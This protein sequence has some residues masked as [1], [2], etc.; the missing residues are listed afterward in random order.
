VAVMILAAGLGTRFRP[1]SAW[2]AKPLAPVGDRPMLSHV[3]ERVRDFGGPIVV[4]A[5]HHREQVR[6]FLEG[7]APNVFISEEKELLGTAGGI[8]RARRYFGGQD[9]LVWNGDILAQLDVQALRGAHESGVGRAGATLVVRPRSRGDGN[10]GVDAAGHVVRLR[11]ETVRPGETRGGEFLGIHVLGEALG[12]R[13]PPSGGLIEDVF[14]P[15]MKEGTHLGVWETT[16]AFHDIGTLETYLAANLAWLE[17]NGLES[18]VGEGAK[19][20]SGVTLVRSV[21]GNGAKLDGQGVVDGCVVWPGTSL[22]APRC[23]SVVSA[24]GEAPL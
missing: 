6:A 7:H 5:H 14:L 2:T 9:V 11:Q 22:S 4:N 24:H 15:A 16:S 18:F 17:E 20:A 12:E 21:V 19:V 13:F 10:V 1:L 8:R 23:N 3:L